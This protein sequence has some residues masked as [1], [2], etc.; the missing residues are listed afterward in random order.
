MCKNVESQ[1]FKFKILKC[2]EVIS[3]NH[4]KNLSPP[5]NLIALKKIFQSKK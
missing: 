5:K 2:L 4:F 3:R 1:K